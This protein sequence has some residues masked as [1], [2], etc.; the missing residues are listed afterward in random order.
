MSGGNGQKYT[1]KIKP[2][3]HRG[4]AL[5][6]LRYMRTLPI[7]SGRLLVIPGETLPEDVVRLQWSIS[8]HLVPII[9]N[10]QLPPID[11]PPGSWS[12]LGN[13]SELTEEQAEILVEESARQGSHVLFVDYVND[14]DF[15]HT[16]SESLKSFLTFHGIKPEDVLLIENKK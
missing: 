1:R 9:P 5:Q 4:L 8:G 15:L 16:A 10:S 6:N 13:A 12:L 3:N 7:P 14:G 11:L 2:I